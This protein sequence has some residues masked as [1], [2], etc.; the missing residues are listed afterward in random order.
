MLREQGCIVWQGSPLDAASC[1]FLA[2]LHFNQHPLIVDLPFPSHSMC[3]LSQDGP[4]DPV[5]TRFLRRQERAADQE[6][7]AGGGVTQLGMSVD[8]LD[9]RARHRYGGMYIG[10]GRGAGVQAEHASP[11]GALMLAEREPLC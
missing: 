1:P 6:L 4:T 2:A 8:E 3:W 7:R 10:R 11:R 5:R 9:E